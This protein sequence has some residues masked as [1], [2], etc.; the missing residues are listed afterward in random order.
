PML[1]RAR[2]GTG[3]TAAEVRDLPR[4]LADRYLQPAGSCYA[5]TEAIRRMVIFDDHDLLREPVTLN[6]DLVVCR[7]VVIYFTDEAKVGLY[8][9]FME[10]L[11]PGG[12][13]F[14]GATE[15]IGRDQD[16]GF[17]YVHLCFYRKPTA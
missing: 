14:L 9:K 11:R 16:P 6:F 12:F 8:R 10:V 17:H 13:L 3:Y 5:V 2:L 7:N 1:D 15:T 4:D